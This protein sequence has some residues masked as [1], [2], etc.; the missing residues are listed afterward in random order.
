MS[1]LC[2]LVDESIQPLWDDCAVNR[3]THILYCIGYKN[4]SPLHKLM[5]L[6]AFNNPKTANEMY[7]SMCGIVIF[8]A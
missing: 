7:L 3:S 4:H 2:V 5:T 8:K 1:V 6:L